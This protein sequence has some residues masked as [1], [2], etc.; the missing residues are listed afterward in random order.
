MF[1]HFIFDS[2]FENLRLVLNVEVSIARFKEE[3][4]KTNVTLRTDQSSKMVGEIKRKGSGK[5][6]CIVSLQIRVRGE[7]DDTLRK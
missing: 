2:K 7:R 6:G 5:F 3:K 4:T 1:K